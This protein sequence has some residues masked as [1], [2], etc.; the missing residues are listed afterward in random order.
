ME[1]KVFIIM[2]KKVLS[3]IFTWIRVLKQAYK[4]QIK[5]IVYVCL[6]ISFD[7]FISK[8]EMLLL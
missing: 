7:L 4:A 2:P 1:E 6:I 8:P 5:K 3:F